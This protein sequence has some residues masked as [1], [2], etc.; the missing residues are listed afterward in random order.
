MFPIL[1]LF[2]LTAVKELTYGGIDQVYIGVMEWKTLM[3]HV[4]S[5]YKFEDK[6]QEE[7]VN[8]FIIHAG[9][10]NDKSSSESD[11][12]IPPAIFVPVFI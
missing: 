2:T 12:I 8:G 9:E 6:P 11:I 10:S 5:N 4:Q 3:E 1:K 7:S